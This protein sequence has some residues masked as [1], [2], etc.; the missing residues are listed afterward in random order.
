[1]K[2]EPGLRRREAPTPTSRLPTATSLRMCASWAQSPVFHQDRTVSRSRTDRSCPASSDQVAEKPST[3][4]GFQRSM[5]DSTFSPSEVETRASCT[6]FASARLTAI[7]VAAWA[8]GSAPSIR[9]R[10]CGLGSCRRCRM[11]A[12]RLWCE[13]ATALGSPVVPDEWVIT[14]GSLPWCR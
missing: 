9:S 2:C 5:A 13:C 14:T 11:E 8:E 6:R 4:S 1:M 10:P 3:H 7:T 12:N